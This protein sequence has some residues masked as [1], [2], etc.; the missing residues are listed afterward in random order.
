MGGKCWLMS[1]EG[2]LRKGGREKRRKCDGKDKRE[3]V[4]LERYITEKEAKKKP[5][6]VR[7]K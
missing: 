7:K 3:K 4:K 5:K 2:K 6:N 1:S